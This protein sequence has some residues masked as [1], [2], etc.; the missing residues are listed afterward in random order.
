MAV[1]QSNIWSS[2]V[3][4]LDDNLT[5]FNTEKELLRTNLDEYQ[6]QVSRLEER[7]AAAVI[8]LDRTRD[9]TNHDGNMSIRKHV[10]NYHVLS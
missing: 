5:K 10:L 7:L 4:T 8:E 2:N 9:P 1:S 6:I 3:G